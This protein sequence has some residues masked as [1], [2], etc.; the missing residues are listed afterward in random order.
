MASYPGAPYRGCVINWSP[1][2]M[3]GPIVDKTPIMA[4]Q[5]I[6]RMARSGCWPMGSQE[7]S[8]PLT[9]PMRVRTCGKR[10]GRGG[11]NEGREKPPPP[12]TGQ[13]RRQGPREPIDRRRDWHQPIR[14]AQ[15]V[16][17][18]HQCQSTAARLVPVQ[19]MP[20]DT[21]G[22]SLSLAQAQGRWTALHR[23]CGHSH[24]R[25]GQQPMVPAAGQRCWPLIGRRCRSNASGRQS[26]WTTGALRFV[27]TGPVMT[28]G[29]V[30]CGRES[31]REGGGAAMYVIRA[32]NACG[33]QL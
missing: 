25:P 14:F 33:N 8:S 13:G 19:A 10:F 29:V 20:T 12:R 16:M 4:S 17:D 2:D 22:T 27:R 1:P 18:R 5:Q 32:S 11:G 30:A 28:A 9:L 3:G 15:E 24:A 7:S 23:A 26:S 6:P 31:T 21:F